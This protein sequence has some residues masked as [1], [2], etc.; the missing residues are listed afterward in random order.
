M[1]TLEWALLDGERALLVTGDLRRARERFDVAY[2]EAAQRGDRPAMARAALGLGGMWAHEHRTA[3]GAAMVRVR[4]REALALLDPG[5][6]PALRLRIRL[7]AEDDYRGGGHEAVLALVAEAR[8]ADVPEAL[9]E[10]LSLA[11]HCA[12]GPD[13]GTLRLELAR[14]LIGVASRTGRRADLLTGLL[15]YAADLLMAADPHAERAL[16]ELRAALEAGPHR[17]IGFVLGAIEVM[18]SIRAGRFAQAEQ[19]AAACHELGTAAGDDNATAWYGCQLAAIRWY[20]G[21]VAELVPRLAGLLGS[22][23]L[24]AVDDSPCA[25]LAL[26]AAAAGDRR[27]AESMLARLRGGV[28]ADRPRTSTWL[29]SMYAVVE[30]AGLLGDAELAAGAAAELAPYAEL[31]VTT[32]PGIAC[33]GSVHHSLGVAA[34]TMGDLDRAAGHLRTAVHENLALGHWPAVALSRSRLGQ[35]LALRDG[36]RD[37]TARREL[38]LAAQEAD[39]LGMTLPPHVS[40]R[41]TCRPCGPRWQV[42]LGARAV[43]VDHCAGMAHLAA[44]LASPGQEITATGLAAGSAG[45]AGPRPVLD[46]P[47]GRAYKDRLAQL[48]AEIDELESNHLRQQA[49]ARRAERDRLVAELASAAGL[50]GR[51]RGLAGG[52]E[53]ARTA[54]GTAIRRAVERIA[55]ADPVIGEELR[56]TVRTGALCSYSPG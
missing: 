51:A 44:L 16:A 17:A 39:A 36:P 50:G 4:Q 29:A 53:R 34:I 38:A 52:Q 48:D 1:E 6:A 35:A 3:A 22:P 7:A 26:A 40:G 32:G 21:R 5:S 8:S 30:A 10:A 25:A 42:E 19:R 14:E 23:T 56:A 28:L 15:W 13:H 33:F 11:H 12:L 41:V 31:P 46:G 37:G 9:A 49:Q 24:S 55:T 54:V 45:S 43:L 27:L 47:A 20:Q 2:R 18:L